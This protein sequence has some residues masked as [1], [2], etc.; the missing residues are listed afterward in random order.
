MKL[1][2][3]QIELLISMVNASIGMAMKSGIPIGEEYYKD[4]DAIKEQ[5]YQALAKGVK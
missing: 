4:I 1:T 5:L 2:K 3:K